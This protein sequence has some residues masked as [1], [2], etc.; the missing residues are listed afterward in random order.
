MQ[1]VMN[2]QRQDQI[3]RYIRG[4]MSEEQRKHFEEQLAQ[5][6]EL[7]AEYEFTEQVRDTLKNRKKKLDLMKQWDEDEECQAVG[8]SSRH[9]RR[10]ILPVAGGF[11]VVAVLVAGFYFG[12]SFQKE[13]ALKHASQVDVSLY[14]NYRSGSAV[15]QIV[16]LIRQERY[17]EAL[18][19]I[20]SEE[21]SLTVQREVVPKT[22]EERERQEYEAEALRQD[23]DHLKWLKVHALM[24]LERRDEALNLLDRLRTA[25]GIYQQKADSLYRV[26]K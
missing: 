25:P 1:N 23:A 15:P 14:E 7:R 10:W 3:D 11:F 18:L 16:A 4:E 17:A 20:E 5:N 6:A 22:D 12:K 21:K 8:V 24:G 13:T 2:E 26:L 19:R 9:R